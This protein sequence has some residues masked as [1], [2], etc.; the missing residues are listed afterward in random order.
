MFSPSLY[1]TVQID[2]NFICLGSLRI[3]SSFLFVCLFLFCFVL[4]CLFVFGGFAVRACK[5]RPP[6]F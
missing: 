4:V 6:C 5:Q 2:E 1:Q 3:G